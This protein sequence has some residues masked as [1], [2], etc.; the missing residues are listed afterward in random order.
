[1]QVPTEYWSNEIIIKLQEWKQYDGILRVDRQIDGI[2]K[3]ARKETNYY[4][5]EILISDKVGKSKEERSIYLI[6]VLFLLLFLKP[7]SVR[8]C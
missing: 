4:M 5:Y 3:T 8:K 7:E 1:M 6:M 2:E